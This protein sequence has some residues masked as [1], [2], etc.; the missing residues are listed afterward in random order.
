MKRFAISIALLA[1]ATGCGN[2]EGAP[3]NAS[4]APSNKTAPTA[5]P[6]P[7][8]TAAM[9]AT[10]A[11]TASAATSASA[12][13][14][15]SADAAPGAVHIHMDSVK[16]TAGKSDDVEKFL[17]KNMLKLRNECVVPQLKKTPTFDGALKAT[18]ELGPDG[19]ATK[20]TT[21]APTGS[22]VPADLLKCVQGFYEKNVQVD[23]N[24]AK[25]TVEATILTGPK[26]T[27]D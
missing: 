14:A 9:T 6:K 21:A 18:I 17:K 7:T 26:V 2:K 12:A 11:T 5:A 3:T 19:K 22:N 16:V 24:K 15:D 23:T 8:M 13:P 20:V 25:A 1:L 10:A 27:T 4:A